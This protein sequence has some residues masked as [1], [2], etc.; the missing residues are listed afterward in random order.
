MIID[1]EDAREAAEFRAKELEPQHSPGRPWPPAM[2]TCR[3]IMPP[4]CCRGTRT[5]P[6]AEIASSLHGRRGL[7]LSVRRAQTMACLPDPNRQLQAHPQAF[8]PIP[9]PS[10]R[11]ARGSRAHNPCHHED[12][13]IL[14][15]L[16]GS[17]D[18][19]ADLIDSDEAAAA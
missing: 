12:L 13:S 5:S 18:D 2:T 8:Q 17:T 9:Q 16:L 1:A 7:D 14:H 3:S 15:R 11:R 6:P 19:L 10:H 4:R